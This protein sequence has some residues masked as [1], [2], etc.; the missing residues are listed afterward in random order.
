MDASHPDDSPA[1]PKPERLARLALAFQHRIDRLPHGADTSWQPVAGMLPMIDRMPE[2]PQRRRVLLALFRRWCGPLPGLE[3]LATPAGRMA[4]LG[5]V[6]LLSRLCTLALLS[7]PGALRCCVELRTRQSLEAAIGPAIGA[8]RECS[9][10]GPAVP[11]IVAAWVP[12]QWACVGY[13]DLTRA[14]AWPHRSL[15][16]L[17]RLA[18]PARWPIPRH[19]RGML[20]LHLPTHEALRRMETLLAGEAAW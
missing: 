4:L 14:G 18:L 10:E 1:A 7:R 19:T 20:P 15:R 17:A 6:Q 3:A 2:G 11:G 12:I 8:L 9:Q 5:R 13:A 16:R